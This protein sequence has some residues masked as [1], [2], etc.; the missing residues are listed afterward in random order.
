M[1]SLDSLSNVKL[2]LGITGSSDDTLLDALRPAADDAILRYCGR[3]FDGGTFTEFAAGGAK[4][5]VLANYPVEAGWELRVDPGRFFSIDAIVPPERVIVRADRGLVSL[6]SG[7]PFISGAAP[8]Q[9][10]QAVRFTYST[11]ASAVPD[12]IRRAYVELIGHWFRQAKTWSITDQQNVRIKTNGTA[13]T[14]YPWG[15][16]GGYALPAGVTTLLDPFRSV[17]V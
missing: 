16:S 1:A 13:V 7:R 6:A 11:A 12:A 14:E 3:R 4:L 2:Q 17:A 8:G 9:Y 10:P 15:Q 5:L